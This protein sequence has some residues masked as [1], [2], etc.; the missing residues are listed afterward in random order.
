[1]FTPAA[2]L[3]VAALDFTGLDES[4]PVVPAPA[5]PPALAP[6]PAPSP[7]AALAA[8]NAARAAIGRPPF[9][10]D[11][12]LARAAQ[13]S[14]DVAGIH[15]DFFGRYRRAGWPVARDGPP[16]AR[17][18]IWNFS[19]GTA[20]GVSNDPAAAGRF[21]GWMMTRSNLADDPR[22]E[23]V[24]DFRAGWTHAGVGLRDGHLVVAY[25]YLPAARLAPR[26]ARSAR[27]V[28]PAPVAYA[29]A[30]V[31]TGTDAA[32]TRPIT[33]MQSYTYTY[34]APTYAAST[35]VVPT[36]A[37]PTYR[38]APSCVGGACAMPAAR[39]A[40]RGLFRRGR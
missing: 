33:H 25:G 2:F 13:A 35:Y 16:D 32:T 36:Y 39:P 29:P 4:E 27:V 40:R 10:W 18:E 7:V 30:R 5:P 15:E 17:R 34:P 38:A 8:L 6:A 11:D 24:W 37:A 9:R 23:H 12:R 22:E 26:G 21:Y 19:E 3:L 20:P 1:V 28:A 31:A 14:A